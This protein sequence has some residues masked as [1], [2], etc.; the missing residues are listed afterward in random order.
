[1]PDTCPIWDLTDLYSGI[2][3]VKLASDVVGC[4]KRGGVTRLLAGQVG[5]T[6][7]DD[8]ATVIG[9]YEDLL[10]QLGRVQV[11][12]VAANTAGQIARHHQ[13]MREMG[14]IMQKFCSLSLPALMNP[15]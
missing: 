8:L 5:W 2:T 10:E 12:V 7:A 14:M 11:D 6:S 3:D 9:T 1:M 4:R 15:T 13:S